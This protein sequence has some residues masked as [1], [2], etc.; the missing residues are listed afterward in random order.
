MR[1]QQCMRG[2][3]GQAMAGV[4]TTSCQKAHN[5]G[6][7]AQQASPAFVADAA[8]DV[9][10]A[11]AQCRAVRCPALRRARPIDLPRRDHN[12]CWVMSEATLSMFSKQCGPSLAQRT[13]WHFEVR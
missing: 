6:R 7:H 4:V 12:H 10:G 5:A 1:T 8:H 3:G 11:W 13:P 9:A 2:G